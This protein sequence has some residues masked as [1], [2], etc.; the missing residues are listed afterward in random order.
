MRQVLLLQQQQQ[1][2]STTHAAGTN[3]AGQHLRVVDTVALVATGLLDACAITA[4]TLP[5]PPWLDTAG[6]SAAPGSP[7][8]QLLLSYAVRQLLPPLVWAAQRVQGCPVNGGK[9]GDGGSGGGGRGGG[10]SSSVAGDVAGSE[11]EQRDRDDLN[12][13]MQ[14]A[15]LKWI[16]ALSLVSLGENEGNEL[17]RAEAELGMGPAGLAAARATGRRTGRGE[18]GVGADTGTSGCS[19]RSSNSGGSACAKAGVHHTGTGE[20]NASGGQERGQDGGGRQQQRQ[21]G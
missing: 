19:S 18:A 12:E 9:P 2:A 20:G 6:G 17:D 5:S 14:A 21:R 11:L 3:R 10:A 4:T 15:C 13:Y 16:G 1:A 7:R 8:L